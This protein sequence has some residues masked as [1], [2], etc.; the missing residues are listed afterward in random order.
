MCLYS[1]SKFKIGTSISVAAH[2]QY[3]G[4]DWDGLRDNAYC[5]RTVLVPEDLWLTNY[6]NKKIVIIQSQ[7][8][9]SN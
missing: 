4:Y 5:D 9:L 1:C 7:N 8:Q 2:S 6:S 3:F